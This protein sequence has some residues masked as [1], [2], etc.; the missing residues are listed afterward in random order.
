MWGGRRRERER[1][2]VILLC[3]YMKTSTIKEK[4]FKEN[5]FRHKR[6]HKN[7]SEFYGIYNVFKRKLVYN[8]IYNL[9]I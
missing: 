1:D 4:I 9:F 5:D 3:E 6:S 2:D 7:V 8:A